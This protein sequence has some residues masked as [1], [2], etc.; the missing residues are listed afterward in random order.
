MNKKR[1]IVLVL[2]LF[3]LLLIIVGAVASYFGVLPPSIS[4]SL[5]YVHTYAGWTFP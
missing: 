3:I 2:I 4:D 5:K 1:K